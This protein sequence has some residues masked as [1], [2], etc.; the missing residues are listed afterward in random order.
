MFITAKFILCPSAR[1]KSNAIEIL[2][3]G[4]DFRSSP[5]HLGLCFSVSHRRR[6]TSF[7]TTSALCNHWPL[8][9][10]DRIWQANGP[11]CKISLTHLRTSPLGRGTLDIVPTASHDIYGPRQRWDCSLFLV[12][13]SVCL[14]PCWIVLPWE[15]FVHQEV[16]WQTQMIRFWG[17]S[18]GRAFLVA[19]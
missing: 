9:I 8:M 6:N 19:R 14:R 12:W 1:P 11:T 15:T 18:H 17:K 7:G 3:S 16:T 4:F 5:Q 10:S 2:C 13:L